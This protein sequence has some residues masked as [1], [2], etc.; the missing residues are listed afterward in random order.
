MAV[1]NSVCVYADDVCIYLS[2]PFTF[3]LLHVYAPYVACMCTDESLQIQVYVVC[4]HYAQ[5]VHVIYA[6]F[7]SN[8]KTFG[9]TFAC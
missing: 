1:N 5:Y 2:G 9:S 3:L 6:R 7:S 4:I 8:L